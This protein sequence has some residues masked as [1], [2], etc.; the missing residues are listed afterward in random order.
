VICGIGE[1]YMFRAVV[2]KLWCAN[3]ACRYEIY[4]VCRGGGWV[5]KCWC[6]FR[7]IL[8][9]VLGLVDVLRLAVWSDCVANLFVRCKVKVNLI[10]WVCGRWKMVG[11]VR[12]KWMGNLYFCVSIHIFCFFFLMFC[13]GLKLGIHQSSHKCRAVS[14]GVALGL[15]WYL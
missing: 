5:C 11:H 10:M 1:R 9:Q 2:P 12:K 7:N 8:R 14:I 3:S 13:G 15:P 4:D 6:F